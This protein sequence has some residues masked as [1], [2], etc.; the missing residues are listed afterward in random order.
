MYRPPEGIPTIEA[1]F[2]IPLQLAAIEPDNQRFDKPISISYHLE[3]LSY[4]RSF[5]SH[6]LGFLSNHP[7]IGRLE[8]SW[9]MVL[10]DAAKAVYAMGPAFLPKLE[11]SQGLDARFYRNFLFGGPSNREGVPIY[12]L[13]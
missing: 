7:Q 5:T 6:L 2:H 8:L 1:S 10:E 13:R 4:D 11:A 3:G 12:P 9:P